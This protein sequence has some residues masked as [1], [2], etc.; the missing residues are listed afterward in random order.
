MSTQKSR[1]A[2]SAKATTAAKAA[3]TKAKATNGHGKEP[4][5]Y[6]DVMKAA[7]LPVDERPKF[8]IGRGGEKIA[9]RRFHLTPEQIAELRKLHDDGDRMPNP[10]KRG[11]YC[12]FLQALKSLGLN[13]PHSYGSVKQAMKAAMS[14]GPKGETLWDRFAPNGDGENAL[15]LDGRIRQ[16]AEVLQRVSLTSFSPYGLKLLQVGQLVLKSKGCVIDILRTKTGDIQFRLNTNSAE[17]LNEL[18]RGH[19]TTP[20]ARAK[21]IRQHRADVIE[22]VI[23]SEQKVSK[24]TGA[25]MVRKVH[26]SVNKRLADRKATATKGAK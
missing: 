14:E 9:P 11:A 4:Q 3:P 15:D 16:N 20:D 2:T 24:T 7:A 12:G 19:G 18:R 25:A 13:K 5:G 10:Q 26:A 23:K 1:K 17:P 21:S 22:K 8:A 6:T